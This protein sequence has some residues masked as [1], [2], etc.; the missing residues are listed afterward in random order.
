[1]SAVIRFLE[2][3]VIFPPDDTASNLD[4]AE[5]DMAAPYYSRRAVSMTLGSATVS[6]VIFA[7]SF[8]NAIF[9]L[10]TP[11]GKNTRSPT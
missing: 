4:P 7:S 9:T 1:M 11:V 6:R 8:A 2:S 3:L 5:I 10:G